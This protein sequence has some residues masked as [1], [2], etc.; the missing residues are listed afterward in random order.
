MILFDIQ[1]DF[2]NKWREKS[3]NVLEESLYKVS[4]ESK[5]LL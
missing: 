1:T 5:I 4:L 2:L 3:R